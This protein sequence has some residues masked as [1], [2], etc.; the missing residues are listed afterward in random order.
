MGLAPNLPFFLRLSFVK[1]VEHLRGI[2][3]LYKLSL[4]ISLASKTDLKTGI[5]CLSFRFIFACSVALGFFLR[6]AVDSKS[7]SG[8]DLLFSSRRLNSI[9]AKVTPLVERV[10]TDHCGFDES[11]TI[12]LLAVGKT[13]ELLPRLFLFICGSIGDFNILLER[14]LEVVVMDLIMA[15]VV[16]TS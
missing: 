13:F 12:L 4:L 5:S 11:T 14:L 6:S 9:L 8:L 3:L 1:G 16:A 2:R 15:M 7:Y 10:L